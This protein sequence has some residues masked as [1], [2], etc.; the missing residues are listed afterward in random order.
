MLRVLANFVTGSK[1]IKI[2]RFAQDNDSTLIDK[3]WSQQA[4]N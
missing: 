4:S 1:L 2:L 3:R